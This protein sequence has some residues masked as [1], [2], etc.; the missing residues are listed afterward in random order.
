MV[1]IM[2]FGA[3]PDDIEIGAGGTVARQ[4]AMGHSVCLVD[5]SA[6]EMGSNGTPDERI[7]ESETARRILGAQ[8]RVNL[9]LPDRGLKNAHDHLTKVVRVIREFRPRLVV[10]PYY[11]DRHPDHIDCSNLVQEACFESGLI[12]RDTGQ[13]PHR[14]RRLLY[15]LLRGLAIPTFIVDTSEYYSTKLE[16]IRAHRSQVEHHGHRTEV[17]DPGFFYFVESRDRYYGS[18]IGTRYGEPIVAPGPLG[19]SDLLTGMFL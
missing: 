2:F 14:P 4:V 11:I 18:L 8:H 6:G 7:A 12:K 9:G 19:I 3:H 1:D 5:L 17:N 13:P 10:A 15:Y 16:S